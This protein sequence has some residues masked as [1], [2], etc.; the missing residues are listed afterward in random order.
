MG[1]VLEYATGDETTPTGWIPPAALPVL[2]IYAHVN[3]CWQTS[4]LMLDPVCK[5]MGTH[6][7]AWTPV[8]WL[9]GCAVTLWAG[10]GWGTAVMFLMSVLSGQ[11]LY[12]VI[13]RYCLGN[14]LLDAKARLAVALR[15]WRV[16]TAALLWLGWVQVPSMLAFICQF[17]IWATAR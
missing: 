15:D 3:L 6:F 10:T 1:L 12:A 14:Q 2:L 17:E 8:A 7:S 16:W 4:R 11:L 13:S 5:Q 9:P